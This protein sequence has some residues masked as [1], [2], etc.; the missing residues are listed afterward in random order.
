M[1]YYLIIHDISPSR[2]DFVGAVLKG[3]VRSNV[4]ICS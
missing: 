1:N 3:T 4:C 2:R